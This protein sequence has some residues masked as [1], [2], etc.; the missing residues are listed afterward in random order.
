M[1]KKNIREA[2]VSDDPT[3]KRWTS[4]VAA[5]QMAYKTGELRRAGSALALGSLILILT[6]LCLSVPAPV[7][8]AVNAVR[9]A[10]LREK[11]NEDREHTRVIALLSPT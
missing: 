3:T 6:I 1:I 2:V 10:E 9:L 8:A 11:F 4:I 5:A 7:Q